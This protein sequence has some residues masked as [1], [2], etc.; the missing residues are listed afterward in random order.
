MVADLAPG[1]VV[2]Y[3]EVA[4]RAGRAGCGASRGSFLAEHGGGL[5]WWRVV[6]ADGTLAVHQPDEQ[7]RRLSALRGGGR[8]PPGLDKRLLGRAPV[9]SDHSTE[10]T[11]TGAT[12]SGGHPSASARSHE[13]GDRHDATG[14]TAL[15]ADGGGPA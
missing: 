15:W 14:A 1:E 2:A 6:R 4:R 3:G 7:A 11:L 13:W 10:G 8:R 9:G 12:G 5:P